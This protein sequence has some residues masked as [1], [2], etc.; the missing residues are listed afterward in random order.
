MRLFKDN[1]N[2]QQQQQ[3]FIYHSNPLP[4]RSHHN[5][6]NSLVVMTQTIMDAIL[7]ITLE[8][9]VFSMYLER[10][11][12]YWLCQNEDEFTLNQYTNNYKKIN[13][14]IVETNC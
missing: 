14:N 9:T 1:S 10:L 7:M 8:F 5:L 6:Y 2:F 12:P 13:S 4:D 11:E 3:Q